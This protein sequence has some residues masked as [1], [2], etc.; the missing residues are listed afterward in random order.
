MSAKQGKGDA[1][2]MVVFLGNPGRQYQ[3]TRHNAG[4]LLLSWVVTQYSLTAPE[5][6]KEKF[7][8]R[9]LKT[10]GGNVGLT[11][12][13]PGDVILLRPEQFI[14]NSGQSVRRGLDFFAIL[15]ERVLV[16]HDDLDTP[17]GE[18]SFVQRG[19]HRGHNGVRSVTQHLG[20]DVFW[21]LRLGTG[22]PRPGQ[23][24]AAWVLERFSRDEAAVLD[25]MWRKGWNAL[26]N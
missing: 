10:T 6:W 17:F 22:R 5:L 3:E 9:F 4:W 7:H 16:V 8:G 2:G 11:D 15:P 25:D 14:N 24:P 1:P 18:V 19:G 21:R 26:S 20:T 12:F 23:A 13:F